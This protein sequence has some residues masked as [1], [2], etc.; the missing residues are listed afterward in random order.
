MNAPHP[1]RLSPQAQARRDA[2]LGDLEQA[3]RNR[4]RRRRATQTATVVAAIALLATG[5]TAIS[6][7]TQSPA[8]TPTPRIANNTEPAPAPANPNEVNDTPAP[9]PIRVAY[10][11]NNTDVLSRSSAKPDASRVHRIDD[12]ALLQSLQAAGLPAGLARTQGEVRLAFYN[13]APDASTN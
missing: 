4:G 2:M 13:P 9:T 8:P 1:T 7:L 6:R 12:E 5:V 10:V 11:T 3:V